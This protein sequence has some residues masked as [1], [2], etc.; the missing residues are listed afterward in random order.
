MVHAD[1]IW[2]DGIGPDN[3]AYMCSGVCCGYGANN[4]PLVQHEIDAHCKAQTDATTQVQKYLIANG[5]WEAQK[6]FDYKSGQSLPN[7]DDDPTTCASKLQKWSAYGADHSNYN[8][9]VA[10]GK[11]FINAF[12]HTRARART[13]TFQNSQVG[14]MEERKMSN[15]R[16]SAWLAVFWLTCRI[17]VP[18]C[19]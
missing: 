16:S 18:T 9:V 17:L 14:N 2:L 13:H 3:G 6:C 7:S 1:G 4:S 12:T 19:A 5:G 11:V 10:Y 15:A 8:F